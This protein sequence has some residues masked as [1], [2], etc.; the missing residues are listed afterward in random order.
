M[1]IEQALKEIKEKLEKTKEELSNIEKDFEESLKRHFYTS[2]W[3]NIKKEEILSFVKKPYIVQPI[4]ENEWRL[5]VPKFIPLEVGWLEYEDESYRVWRVN[6][7]IDWITPIPDV[8]KEE[9]GFEKPNLEL[10]FDWEKGILN[11][12]KGDIKEVKKR[13][14]SFIFKQLDHSVFQIKSP[15]RFNFLVQLLKDGILPY[16]PKPVDPNDLNDREIF[17]LRDYQKEA[18]NLF[19]KYSHLLIVFPFGT[20]KSFFALY[21]LAKV[22]GKKLVVVP[23]RTLIEQW[24]ERILKYCPDELANTTVITYQSLHKVA[25]TTFDLII[26]DECHHSPSDTFSRVFFIKRKYTLGLSGS[27]YREDGRTELI[28]TIGYPVGA[29][30]NYFFKKGIIKK[31]KVYVILV[32]K[33]E[34]KVFELSKLLETKSLTLIYCDSIAQGKELAKKFNL[35]FVYSETRKRMDKIEEA[36]DKKGAVILSRIGDE[37]ISLPDIQRVIEFSFLY[38][39]RRQ[40]SQRYGRLLHALSEGE[41]YILMTYD[42][43]ESYKKRL[44]SI[45]EKGIEIEFIKR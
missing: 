12:E 7:Y 21:V 2:I 37:G 43:F 41:H 45:L 25:N 26:I 11:V 5:I 33:L 38:G 14:G 8:L 24:E 39:S 15:R 13:Y 4:G 35:D 9:L 17:E 29:D 6:R 27:P 30:W 23:T 3:K 42:E 34:E 16:R 36:L 44:Y 32:Q 1:E 40:E 19:L 22:K 31:P 10:S 18:Y 28:Y 20:G